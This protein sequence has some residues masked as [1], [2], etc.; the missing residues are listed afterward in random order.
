M[1]TTPVLNL[2]VMRYRTVSAGQDPRG[3]FAI[4]YNAGQAVDQGLQ[5]LEGRFEQGLGS[6]SD[7]LGTVRGFHV[8][9]AGKYIVAPFE[10]DSFFNVVVDLRDP[11]LATFGLCDVIELVPGIAVYVPPG[12]GNALQ[13]RNEKAVY[14]YMT[15]GTYVG[16]EERTVSAL[17]PTIGVRWPL[18]IG[19]MSDK[20]RAGLSIGDYLDKLPSHITREP[21]V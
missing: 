7:I 16:S 18:P 6:R 9:T 21:F 20:D 3:P 10:G 12:Y 15:D 4:F 19:F 5:L 8:S 14:I 13:N 17:D 1:E 11:R 2:T